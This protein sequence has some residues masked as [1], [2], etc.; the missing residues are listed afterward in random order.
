[1][2]RMAG[3]SATSMFQHNIKMNKD[4]HYPKLVKETGWH[5][6]STDV[7]TVALVV[8]GIENV[9]NPTCAPVATDPDEVALFHLQKQKQRFFYNVLLL[10][11]SNVETDVLG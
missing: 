5:K 3:M 4:D 1:M 2:T 7:T 11:R 9:L 6:F 10:L 8:H